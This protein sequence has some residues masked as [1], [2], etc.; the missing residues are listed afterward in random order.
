[1]DYKEIIF[2]VKPNEP[3]S[4]ILID[5]LANNMGY[6][7]FEE[8]PDGF[9]AYIQADKFDEE[10]LK[11][12][13]LG[14]MFNKKINVEFFPQDVE[15]TNWN[16]EW[17]K[18]YNPVVVSEKCY[19]R[20]PFHKPRPDIPLEIVIEPKMSFGTGHH[21]TTTLVVEFLFDTNLKNKS[22]LDMGCG[23]GVLAIIAAKLGASPVTAIDNHIYAYENTIENARYNN[24][25]INVLHNDSKVLGKDFYDIIIANI[26]KNILLND[27]DKYVPVLKPGG[28]LILSGFFKADVGDM[29]KKA[30][31]LGI[32][33]KQKKYCNNWA[34]LKLIN[35]E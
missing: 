8:R 17:E 9:K 3:W 27:M 14:K 23:T 31:K 18:N 10:K 33:L 12:I 1:M 25:K 4:E 32:T 35:K 20:A 26:T 6:E 11:E 2:N 5:Y 30:N 34:A 24:T 21:A 29:E 15:N 13:D 16:E 7:S 28:I 19:I 22:V